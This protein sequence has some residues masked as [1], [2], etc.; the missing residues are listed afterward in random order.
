MGLGK[1]VQAIAF[2]AHLYMSENKGPHLVVV[3]ASTL[4]NWI[5]EF[6][7]WCPDMNIL[8]YYGSQEDRK[9]LRY[10]IL[11]KV[12]ELNVIVT[13]YNCAIS[14]AEDRSLFR[15][16][17]LDYAVFDEGHMLKNM[18]AIRYQHL[19]T[20]NAKHRLL[21][22]GTPVQNNLLELMS[23][24][25]FV[26]PHMFSSSTSE[27]KRMFSSKAKSTDE[28][29][30]FEK[31]RIAHAKRIMRPF[32]LRRVKS[33]V[34]K[35]LPPKQDHIKFCPLSK[36]QQQMYNDLMNKLKRSVEGTE[37]NTELCNVMMHLRK[38]ANHPLL[39]RQYYTAEKLRSM[40]KLML[41]I[42]HSV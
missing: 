6:N 3:P 19:M 8:L 2:L 21:L 16:L 36:K 25:N 23:L 34:L 4:D 30:I 7:Q 14:N 22:T 26:M 5:R 37:K 35:Q 12:I 20:L 40:S 10:D 9:H 31:G 11:N 15:R 38:M 32:I 33:E 13:T 27:L 1:T 18:S 24:L 39:H 29:S 41:K 42:L 17:K 28:Q